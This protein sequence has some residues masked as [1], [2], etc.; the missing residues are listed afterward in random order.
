M[1]RKISPAL[2]HALLSKIESLKQEDAYMKNIF[3]SH[4]P[5]G[6]SSIDD[7][8]VNGQVGTT[9]PK[10]FGAVDTF[11]ANPSNVAIGILS[12]MIE[13]DP[14]VMSSVQFKSLMMLSKIGEY[15]HEDPEIQD[16][17]RDFLAKMDGPTFKQSLEGQSSNTGYGF[18]VSEKIYGINKKN[19]KVPVK[20]K[21]YHP[22]T[23]VF[24]VDPYGEITPEGIV[25]FTI[26]Y[27]QLSNPNVYFPVFQ[28]G[29][30]VK[31]PFETPNDRVLPYRLPFI[32]NYGLARIPKSKCIHHVSGSVM[33]FGSPYGKSNVRT[34]HLAWQLKVFFLKQMGIAGKRQA[35]PFIWATA[36]HNQNKTEY[37]D[38]R[39]KKEIGKSTRLNSSHVKRSR[40]P[41]SA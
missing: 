17:V 31:N 11:I 15:Q 34:A 13:T 25:Q 3:G 23:L 30:N 7:T 32:G 33:S 26:Q 5:G 41:S 28:Y 22:S 4:T 14:T 39:G 12:R 29:F 21:T 2:E 9:V 40:M 1:T 19:Q 18:S 37:Q 38:H 35:S 27:G 8:S 16:F 6:A 10:Y 36:P 20:I 24:E